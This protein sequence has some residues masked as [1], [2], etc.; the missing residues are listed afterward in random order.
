LCPFHAKFN[1]LF[2]NGR[3]RRGYLIK[4][5]KNEIFVENIDG[6]DYGFLLSVIKKYPKLFGIH[7][8]GKSL[9]I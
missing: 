2:E 1:E 6:I 7:K 9:I 4:A 5:L 8:N 3:S